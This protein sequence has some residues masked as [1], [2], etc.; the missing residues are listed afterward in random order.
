ML[1]SALT[2]AMN[3]QVE[4]DEETKMIIIGD[5]KAAINEIKDNTLLY[6]VFPN[7]MVLEMND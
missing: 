5:S 1:L 2:E 3:K 4:W 6:S 7:I